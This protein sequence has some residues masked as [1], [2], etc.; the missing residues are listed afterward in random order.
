MG[1][2]LCRLTPGFAAV[3]ALTPAL[4]Q[5]WEQQGRSSVVTAASLGVG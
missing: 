1:A 2:L 4:L 3:P 5:L